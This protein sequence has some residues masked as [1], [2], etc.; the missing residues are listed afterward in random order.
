L[1]LRYPDHA[2][3]NL[4]EYVGAEVADTIRFALAHDRGRRG[5]E[6]LDTDRPVQEWYPEV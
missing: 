3:K 5:D 6:A 1:L 4:P 2:V